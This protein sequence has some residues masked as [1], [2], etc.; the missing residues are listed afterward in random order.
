MLRWKVTQEESG[1]QLL[2]FLKSKLPADYSTRSLKRFLDSNLCRVNDR[3]ERFA[4][5]V[6]GY[7]DQVE[8]LESSKQAKSKVQLEDQR[9]LYQDADLFIYDKPSGIPADS[10]ELLHALQ[11]DWPF[12]K[13]AHRLDRDT[14][15]VLIFAR[16]PEA[17]EK[18]NDLFKKRKVQKKYLAIVDGIPEKQSGIIDNYLGVLHKYQGQTLYGQVQKSKGLHSITEWELAKTGKGAA[19]LSCFP[20]TG[21]THQLR[22]HLAEMGHPILGDFQ[23]GHKFRS[24]YR[25]GRYLLH[26][27]SVVFMHP[28]TEQIIEVH[29]PI[30]VDFQQAIEEIS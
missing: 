10:E 16:T 24:T 25:P 29:A 15:G 18:M 20:K 26:A 27:E 23:Y 7:G 12:L 9:I 21:R 4:S 30:P 3:T 14:T 19:L 28:V 5:Y 11:G 22:V 17:L 2:S 1:T 6:L 8:L 13:L